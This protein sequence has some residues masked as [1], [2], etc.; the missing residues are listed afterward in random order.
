MQ[1]RN[2]AVLL[3]VQS[4]KASVTITSRYD[5]IIKKLHFAV[6]DVAQTGDALVEIEV[7]GGAAE[8][9]EQPHQGGSPEVEV[10]DTDAINVGEKKPSEGSER[11]SA[12][13]LATPAVRRMASEHGLELSEIVGT[14]KDG[15]VLKEDIINHLESR[16]TPAV[17]RPVPPAAAAAPVRKPEPVLQVHPAPKRAVVT[18]PVGQDRTEPIKGIK[19]AMNRTMT[20]A[21]TIPHLVSNQT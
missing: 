14:G 2:I 10:Q 17:P 20:E 9:G 11:R 3:Q 13:A 16:P 1:Q 5:G 12:K 21:L 8:A 15:R 18:T 4:D 6:D 19:K 7:S